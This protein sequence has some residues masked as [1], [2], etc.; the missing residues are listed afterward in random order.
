MQETT[1][2]WEVN[3]FLWEEI[4]RKKEIPK[5]CHETRWGLPSKDGA[6][7]PPSAARWTVLKREAN[8]VSTEWFCL[9]LKRL[10]MCG[11][12]QFWVATWKQFTFTLQSWTLSVQHRRYVFSHPSDPQLL[13]KQLWVLLQEGEKP[14]ECMQSCG[15]KKSAG[16]CKNMN[17]ETVWIVFWW[18]VEGINAFQVNIPMTINSVCAAAQK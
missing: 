7:S 17:D 4:W 14:T 10:R 5:I 16:F 1:Y 18:E 11:A 6:N 8:N 13:V 12:D 15:K 3:V 9:T 2:L